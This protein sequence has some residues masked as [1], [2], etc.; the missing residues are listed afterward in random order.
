MNDEGLQDSAV[1]LMAIGE[2]SAS[3][4][5]KFLSA[6]E[7]HRVSEAMARIRNISR[8]RIDRILNRF[9]S[10][11]EEATAIGVNSD[12]YL[13]KVL[14]AAL[15]EEKAALLLDRVLQGSDT[16]GIERLRWVEPS[17][18]VPEPSDTLGPIVEFVMVT[19]S[20]M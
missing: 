5:F 13:R 14:A 7:V 2:E 4:V 8:D 15:G 11:A 3:E 17:T 1:L 18:V 16:A 9:Q 12:D 19:S 6:K 20:S 10:S